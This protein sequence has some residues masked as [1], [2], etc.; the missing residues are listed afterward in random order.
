LKVFGTTNLYVIGASVFRTS[1]N[2]NTTFTALTLVTRL[3]EHFGRQS[4]AF[5]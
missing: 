4:P 1:S 3:G 5:R 2:A